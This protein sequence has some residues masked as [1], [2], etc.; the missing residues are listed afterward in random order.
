[1]DNQYFIIY[2]LPWVGK[3]TDKPT[4]VDLSAHL[5]RYMTLVDLSA[6]LISHLQWMLLLNQNIPVNSVINSF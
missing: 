5:I 3:C 4:L 1:M 2:C 6:D